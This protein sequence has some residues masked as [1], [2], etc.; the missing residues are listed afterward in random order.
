MISRSQLSV[1]EIHDLLSIFGN[2]VEAASNKIAMSTAYH[3]FTL[4]PK[5]WETSST[6]L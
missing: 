2:I 5:L 3:I 6:S 4:L 1:I